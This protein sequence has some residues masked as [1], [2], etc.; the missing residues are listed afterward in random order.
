VDQRLAA[1]NGTRPT[2]WDK[3]PVEALR[4]NPTR[5]DT[6][7]SP[8]RTLDNS[9]RC[10]RTPCPVDRRARPDDAKLLGF[11]ATALELIKER[12]LHQ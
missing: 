12:V 7:R 10:Q 3:P 4:R 11:V 9:Q 2:R 1:P 6:R 8:Q 5:R